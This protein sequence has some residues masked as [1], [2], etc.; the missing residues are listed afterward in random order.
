[1]FTGGHLHEPGCSSTISRLVPVVRVE[2]IGLEE[3]GI[4]GLRAV[5]AAA[6]TSRYAILQGSLSLQ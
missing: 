5:C 3:L 4:R 6:E 2:G 1:M